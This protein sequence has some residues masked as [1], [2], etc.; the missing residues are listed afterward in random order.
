[1]PS[2]DSGPAWVGVHPSISDKP[3]ADGRDIFTN[4]FEALRAFEA[5]AIPAVPLDV[6][7]PIV[8]SVAAIV[9]TDG[10]GVGHR[11]PT[12]GL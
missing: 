6:S 3:M 4:V 12:R 11:G 8:A 5:N 10:L 1:M 7:P 2:G 9:A